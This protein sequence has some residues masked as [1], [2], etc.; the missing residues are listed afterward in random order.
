MPALITRRLESYETQ[1][2]ALATDAERYRK[3]RRQLAAQRL[4]SPLFDTALSVRLLENA[5]QEMWERCIHGHAP[6]QIR[7][8][9]PI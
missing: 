6:G 8:G 5:Y 7:V 1:A 9:A 4:R 3:T 2:V